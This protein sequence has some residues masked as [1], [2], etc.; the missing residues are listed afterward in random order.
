MLCC[1]HQE[2]LQ[3]FFPPLLF[4]NSF[5]KASIIFFVHFFFLIARF[6]FFSECRLTHT[7]FSPTHFS[8]ANH[9][10]TQEE[11]HL[12]LICRFSV[13]SESQP[14]TERNPSQPFI[15]HKSQSKLVHQST[16]LFAYLSHS[17]SLHTK[18]TPYI[19]ISLSISSLP[20]LFL[21]T[22]NRYTYIKS[23]E[24]KKRR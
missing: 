9:I 5:D 22:E 21:N 16:S 23:K 24:R 4:H 11:P 2:L 7:F 15:P 8:L 17:L 12:S 14:T 19:F 6:F 20:P 10:H 13:R 18:H 1:V 3:L